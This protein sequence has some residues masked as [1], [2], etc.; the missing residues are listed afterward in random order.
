MKRE[1]LSHNL[2]HVVVLIGSQATGE[3]DSLGCIG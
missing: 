2:I 1:G 3:V